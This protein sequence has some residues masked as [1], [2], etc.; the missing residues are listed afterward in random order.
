MQSAGQSLRASLVLWR[1]RMSRVRDGLAARRAGVLARRA[2]LAPV[3]PEPIHIGDAEAAARL[4]GGALG[5]AGAS[6]ALRGR[7]P[8][9]VAAPSAA[10]FSALHGFDWLD[11]AL[12][13]GKADRAVLLGW[14]FDWLGR[15]G[16]GGGPS[17]TP[18]L[19]GRRLARLATAAPGLLKRA[20]PSESRA[21]LRALRVHLAFLR[22][23]AAAAETPGDRLEA[24]TGL[25]LGSLAVAGATRSL[26]RARSVLAREAA[27]V[28]GDG[29]VPTRDPGL[30][31][32]GFVLLAWTAH[33]MT[34]AGH[35]PDARHLAALGRLGPALRALRLGDGGLPRFHGAASSPPGMAAGLLDHAFAMAGAAARGPRQQRCMG[36][37]RLSA[38]RTVVI[39]DAA[40]PPPDAPRA[41]AS[42]LALE[43]SVGRHRVFGSIGPGEGLGGE[44]AVA[45]R[46]TAAHSAVEVAGTSSARLMPDGRAASVLGRPLRSGPTAVEVERTD[47]LDGQWLRAEHDGYLARFGLTVSR[48]LHL[49]RDG[50]DFRGEDTLTCPTPEAQRRFDRAA[51]RG[52]IAFCVRFHLAPEVEA[53]RYLGGRAVRMR[54]PDGGFWVVRCSGGSIGL[55]E[56]LWLDEAAGRMRPT[57]Q[58]VISARAEGYFGRVS[59]A[60][61]RADGAA[62]A[63]REVGGRVSV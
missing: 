27:A 35:G 47:D 59:W 62:E 45:A 55:A 10:W 57:R 23:R 53:E 29:G 44:W 32:Q 20:G 38:G 9:A 22:A 2:A 58:I 19:A 15:F 41:A 37:E 5:F 31:A 21:L 46:A 25:L 17:W 52:G 30:V 13:A 42:T 39:V 61:N 1:R 11:D 7:S 49:S 34:A 40:P 60:L 51:E 8:W 3:G 4:A 12:V 26:A 43:L 36:F 33:D 14:L 48:R 63:L 56:S 50:C 18:V 28:A 54:L 16:R 24:G 6:V